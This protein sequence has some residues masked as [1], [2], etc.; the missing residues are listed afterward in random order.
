M[1]TLVTSVTLVTF[2]ISFVINSFVI[3]NTSGCGGGGGIRTTTVDC[4]NVSTNPLVRYV[5]STSLIAASP[6]NG[7]ELSF[8]VV[9]L[10]DL[11]PFVNLNFGVGLL[12]GSLKKNEPF[13]SPKASEIN[14]ILLTV[15]VAPLVLPTNFNPFLIRPKNRP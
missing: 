4:L 9:N 12:S 7:A 8:L 10:N 15:A 13:K 14:L 11:T 3:L 1:V 6:S 5:V 2:V